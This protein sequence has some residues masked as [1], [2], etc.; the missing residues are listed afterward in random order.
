MKRWEAGVLPEDRI[1]D[2]YIKQHREEIEADKFETRQF[3]KK[4]NWL[5]LK[6]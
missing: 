1:L 4:K 6:T 3:K 2:K 5:L